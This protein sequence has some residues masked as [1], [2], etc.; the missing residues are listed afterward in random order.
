[1]LQKNGY[2]L[3]TIELCLVISV[4]NEKLMVLKRFL[5]EVI[6]WFMTEATQELYVEQ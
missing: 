3:D 1:M 5:V 6:S 2:V 4:A